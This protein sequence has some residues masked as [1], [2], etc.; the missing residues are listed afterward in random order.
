MTN[1]FTDDELR[2]AFAPALR[3]A[4]TPHGPT[5]PTPEALRAAAS[6]ESP[7]AEQLRTLDLA[8][9]CAAC[10]RELALLYAVS[11]AH[12]TPARESGRVAGGI[13]RWPR[14]VPFAL[15]ASLVIAAGLAGVDRWRQRTPEDALRA[16]MVATDPSPVAPAEGATLRA[17][18]P[19]AFAWRA[20]PGTLHYT[21]EVV[22]TDGTVV[23]TAQTADTTFAAPSLAAATPGEYR[24][25]VRAASDDGSTRRSA[26]RRLV[27]R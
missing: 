4:P 16:G 15:A 19:I 21:V 12:A 5:C 23:L 25:S 14:L 20:V 3:D 6:G 11:G 18:A 2:A 9:G 8:L 17:A 26:A 7:G 13:G 10:R 24:W 27:V 1:D 22:A